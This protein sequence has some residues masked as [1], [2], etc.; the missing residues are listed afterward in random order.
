MVN[1]ETIEAI[2]RRDGNRCN[3]CGAEGVPLYV[4]HS[5][6]YLLGGQDTIE[7]LQLLC[8]NCHLKIHNQ[9]LSEIRGYDFVNYLFQI[10]QLSKKF[11]NVKAQDGSI[12]LGVDIVAEEMIDDSWQ[13]VSIEC[14]AI[15]SF[16]QSRLSVT[17]QQLKFIKEQLGQKRLIFAFLGET[18]ETMRALSKKYD[19]EIWDSPFIAQTFRQEIQR[20]KHPTLQAMFLA[21]KASKASTVL[22]P[23]AQLIQEL[24]SLMPGKRD[25]MKYQDLIKR[26]FERLFC[27]PLSAPIA[28]LPDSLGVN[29]RDI[30]IPNYAE[31]GF[32]KFIRS[33]YSAEYIVVDTKNYNKK[34]EKQSVLQVSNYLKRQGAGLFGIIVC[35]REVGFSCKHTVEAIWSDY[36]KLI[37]VL[38]DED[39]EKMLIEKASSRKPE[40]IIR[41][42]IEDFRLAL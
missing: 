35:R 15:S 27:P 37:I 6:P 23:E 2:K 13:H 7:N 41:Q 9:S 19:I 1:K 29:R 39:I 26:I 30:I 14:K 40:V 12:D 11:R 3:N 4:H 16:T 21:V 20:I 17:F 25:C 10:L 38:T 33:R 34:I 32:W 31:Q 18:N 28:E 22:S 24:R 42:K 36:K 8:E 5:I